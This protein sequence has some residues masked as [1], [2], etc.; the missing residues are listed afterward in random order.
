MLKLCGLTSHWIRDIPLSQHNLNQTGLQVILGINPS[1]GTSTPYY[2]AS[3]PFVANSIGLWS[4]T[5][6]PFIN[7]YQVSA[8]LAQPEIVNNVE[9]KNTK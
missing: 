8:K 1:Y 5:G 3:T 6:T 7:A 9:V 4:Q 2:S